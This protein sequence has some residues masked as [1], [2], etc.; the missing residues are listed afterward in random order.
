VR[1]TSFRPCQGW[2][3]PSVRER[4]RNYK[5]FD[6][7]SKRPQNHKPELIHTKRYSRTGN[8]RARSS[9]IQG[10]LFTSSR[11]TRKNRGCARHLAA[12]LQNH[13]CYMFIQIIKNYLLQQYIKVFI[14]VT[15]LYDKYELNSPCWEGG[16]LTG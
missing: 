7:I 11:R 16:R 1:I 12:R 3:R 10:D 13:T 8:R 9:R 14:L 6:S 15:S 5:D 2:M 4:H